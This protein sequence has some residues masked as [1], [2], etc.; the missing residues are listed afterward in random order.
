MNAVDGRAEVSPLLEVELLANGHEPFH[1]GGFESDEYPLASG[2][3]GQI[4][5]F[6][7]VG[8][9]PLKTQLISSL[10]AANLLGNFRFLGNVED[11]ML[12]TVYNCADVFVLPSIQEGQGIVMLEAQASG[13]PVVA[14]DVGGVNEAARNDETGLLVER[15]NTDELANALL[16]L[17][18]DSS[19]RLRMGSNGRRYVAE[20][21]TWDI[22]ARKM[23]SV[24]REALGQ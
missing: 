21:Y 5:Q 14:F 1:G 4:Q 24:Y 10:E 9:G 7:I 17:L 19:L 3:R 11:E 23:L 2:T 22:C 13:K 16:K 18:G 6:L 12:P 20:N 15:G 8:E